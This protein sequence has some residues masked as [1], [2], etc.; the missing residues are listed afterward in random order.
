MDRTADPCED[1]YQFTCGNWGRTHPVKDTDVSNTWFNERSQF[2]LRQLKGQSSD[3]SIN[4]NSLQL[5]Y[6]LFVTSV[7]TF[8]NDG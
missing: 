8:I 2:L 5:S 4:N 1:F 6:S 7:V 3:T